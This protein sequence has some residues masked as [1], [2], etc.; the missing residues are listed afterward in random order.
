MT[1][2]A[3]K[4][5]F[6]APDQDE[7]HA[8][9]R[10]YR[11]LERDR[12]RWMLD[13]PFLGSLAMRLD[14]V[15]VVD[16]RL[17]T[18]A[19]DGERIFF[20]ARFAEQLDAGTRR[21]VLAH[22]VWHCAALHVPRRG[23]RAPDLWNLAIDHETNSV[24]RQQGFELPEGVVH[25]PRYVGKNAETVHA[26]LQSDRLTAKPR[27]PLADLHDPA[28][29]ARH[30]TAGES[31]GDVHEET[32]DSSASDDAPSRREPPQQ[33]RDPDYRPGSGSDAKTWARWPRQV[34]AAAQIHKR[35]HGNHPGWLD[36]LLDIVGAPS[37]PWQEVL[38][39]FAER[40]VGDRYRWTRPNRRFAGQ[41]LYLP[42]RSA[43]R[44]RLAVGLDVSGSTLDQIPRF[45]AELNDILRAFER[46][47]IRIIACDTRCVF[48]QRFDQNTPPTSTINLKNAGGGTELQPVFDAI[49]Q[50]DHAALVFLTDGYANPPERPRYPVLWALTDDG[51]PPADWGDVLRLDPPER[52]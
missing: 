7:Q 35:L 5:G 49:E 36:Q 23:S 32:G 16:S 17:P 51:V 8:K 33:V 6:R 14:L 2:A 46:Y 47:E 45:M 43:T 37:V 12:A 27:G 9:Q 1:L 4:P 28:R 48:D 20:N 29:R 50:D 19:T 39:R 22:E 24:L 38:R 18:A 25:F 13:Q 30:R 42:S 34:V 26:A 3:G 10:V 31:D 11:L 40:C 41:G 52:P 44:L 15:P 21:F